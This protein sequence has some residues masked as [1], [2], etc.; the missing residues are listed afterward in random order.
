LKRVIVIASL[1]TLLIPSTVTLDDII[2]NA[3][4]PKIIEEKITQERLSLESES[5]LL[6]SPRTY[7]C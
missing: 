5:P 7:I 3:K 1:S 2:A 6:N 4:P